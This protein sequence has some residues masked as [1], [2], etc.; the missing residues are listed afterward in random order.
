MCRSSSHLFIGHDDS[1]GFTLSYNQ[2]LFAG[3]I[4]LPKIAI[5]GMPTTP[6]TCITPESGS[7]AAEH[8]ERIAAIAITVVCPV[9]LI[10]L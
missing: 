9:R 7:T 4:T 5:V 3:G 2:I 10:E 1:I 6:A 8:T